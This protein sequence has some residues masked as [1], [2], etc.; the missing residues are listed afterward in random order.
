MLTRM[1][2]H[3]YIHILIHTCAHPPTCTHIH[4]LIHMGTC[5]HTYRKLKIYKKRI[6]YKIAA[7]PF[8]GWGLEQ[9]EPPL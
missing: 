6:K 1:C 4:I 9:V 3:T 5:T 7:L 2:M 8:P